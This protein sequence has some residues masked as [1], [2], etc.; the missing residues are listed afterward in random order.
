ML[1]GSSTHQHHS[2]YKKPSDNRVIVKIASKNAKTSHSSANLAS[3]NQA[4]SSA[5]STPVTA[6]LNQKSSHLP[7]GAGGNSA[8]RQYYA[9]N[10]SSGA[11]GQMIDLSSQ[12]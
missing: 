4:G 8:T 12:Q 6:I 1:S 2:H 11:G 5:Q 3:G 10:S 9:V 7:R